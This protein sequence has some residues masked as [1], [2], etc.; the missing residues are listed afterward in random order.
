MTTAVRYSDVRQLGSALVAVVIMLASA[1]L[2]ERFIPAVA[3]QEPAPALARAP[4]LAAKTVGSIAV[5]HERPP[6]AEV[7]PRVPEQLVMLVAGAVL[8]GLGGALRPRRDR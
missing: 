3:S 4:M 8:I 1:A 7:P 6:A 2:S 5:M